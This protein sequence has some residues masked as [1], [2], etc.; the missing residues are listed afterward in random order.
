ML[1]YAGLVLAKL[2][3][4]SEFRLKYFIYVKNKTFSVLKNLVLEMY[5]LKSFIDLDSA[6][7]LHK[8]DY[9]QL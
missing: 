6:T 5:M 4:N 8:I 2:L 9:Q 1:Q 3:Q 7:L